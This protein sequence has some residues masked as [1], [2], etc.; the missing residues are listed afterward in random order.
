ML[1]LPI[2]A[3]LASAPRA[4]TVPPTSQSPLSCLRQFP[5]YASYSFYLSIDVSTG[6]DVRKHV[7]ELLPRYAAKFADEHPGSNVSS[8][9]SYIFVATDTA[10]ALEYQ[11]GELGKLE[12]RG[13]KQNYFAEDAKCVNGL[14][15][16]ALEEQSEHHADLAKMPKASGFLEQLIQTVKTDQDIL[17]QGAPWADLH[18]WMKPPPGPPREPDVT[19][20][21][22][23]YFERPYPAPEAAW[24]YFAM[25]GVGDPDAA[26]K[27]VD[28]M[29][30]GAP[31]QE[32][33]QRVE[34][35]VP[36][37]RS[38]LR[39]VYRVPLNRGPEIE[40]K[41]RAL[42]HVVKVDLGKVAQPYVINEINWRIAQLEK[43]V[44]SGPDAIPGFTIDSKKAQA[45]L[46]D[47]KVDRDRFNAAKSQMSVTIDLFR[48]DANSK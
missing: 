40:P 34:D 35:T 16:G 41:L 12:S 4:A 19:A 15:A 5:T 31:S 47:I 3:V 2:L 24:N 21:P 27:S 33:L 32:P 1:A 30:G 20:L 18:V 44:A 10:E 6:T 46:A 8:A 48:E 9:A 39:R 29:F 25:I 7:E 23:D 11:I 36:I 28:E 26:L 45:I 37:R 13:F 42:G 43:V 14:L 38:V 17:K 22:R